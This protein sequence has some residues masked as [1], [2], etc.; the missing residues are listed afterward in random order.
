MSATCLQRVA[1]TLASGI[2]ERRDIRRPLERDVVP[3]ANGL[4]VGQG[5]VL[6]GQPPTEYLQLLAA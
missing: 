2:D 1:A 6:V 4:S 3:A 5:L